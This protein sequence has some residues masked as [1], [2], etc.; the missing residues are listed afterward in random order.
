VNSKTSATKTNT[1]P[2][3]PKR[4]N[5]M[6]L[7]Q[8]QPKLNSKTKIENKEIVLPKNNFNKKRENKRFKEKYFNREIGVYK[9]GELVGSGKL[10]F[11]NNRIN[12]QIK[13][14]L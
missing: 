8:K 11:E 3:K 10:F 1:R 2:Y 14:I 6:K 13:N 4:M 12:L 7:D 9:E 5:F